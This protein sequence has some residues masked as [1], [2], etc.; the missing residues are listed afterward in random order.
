MKDV[1]DDLYKI[2]GIEK[3]TLYTILSSSE[4]G[5]LATWLSRLDDVADFMRGN[6]RAKTLAKKVTDYLALAEKN[7]EFRKLFFAIIQDATT[8]CGDRVA[9]SILHVG[10][11]KRLAEVNPR[12]L[13][14][15]SQLLIRGSW[16]ISQLEKIARE[17]VEILKTTVGLFDEIE[18]YLGY[19]IKLRKRLHLPI[20]IEAMLFFN[21]SNIT[22]VLDNRATLGAEQ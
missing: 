12:D 22:R 8:S 9:L 13:T 2:S 21:C 15:L 1:I 18:V 3:P 4:V 20:D 7:Q 17:K 16:I 10:M 6:E 11:A 19:P 5:Y 14:K